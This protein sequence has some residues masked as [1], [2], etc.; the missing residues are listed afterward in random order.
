MDACVE[1]P[2]FFWTIPIAH[3]HR[4]SALMDSRP[5]RKFVH[6]VVVALQCFRSAS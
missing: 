5:H 4:M 2:P 1:A 6:S 3:L